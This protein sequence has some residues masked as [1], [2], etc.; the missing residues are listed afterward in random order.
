MVQAFPN[1]GMIQHHEIG[2]PLHNLMMYYGAKPVSPR[3]LRLLLDGCRETLMLVRNAEG[4]L[5]L[6]VYTSE[7]CE[8]WRWE[9]WN[10]NE[11]HTSTTTPA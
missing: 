6:Q 2:L 11:Q 7:R 3:R 10:E 9:R 1:D 4:K 5:P 8:A